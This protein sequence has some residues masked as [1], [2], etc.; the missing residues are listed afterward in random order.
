MTQAQHKKY[1]ELSAAGWEYS[2]DGECYGHA[3]SDV[4]MKRVE[5]HPEFQREL[6]TGILK[7]NGQFEQ[8]D[9]S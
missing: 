4:H 2:H 8:R 7:P 3:G 5:Y 9:A 1:D 6:A